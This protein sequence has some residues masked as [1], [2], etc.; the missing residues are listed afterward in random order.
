MKRF[1]KIV[2]CIVAVAAML[3]TLCSCEREPGLYAWYGKVD[4]DNILTMTVNVDGTEKKYDVP[5]MEYRDLFVHY[6]TLVS[7]TVVNSKN[8]EKIATDDQK[9]KAL[10]EYTE[11]EL[12]TYYALVA[13][14]DKFGVPITDDDRAAYENDYNAIVLS[15]ADKLSDEDIKDFDGTKEDYASFVYGKI[16]EKLG[17]TKEYIKYSYFK[18]LLQRKIRTALAPDLAKTVGETYCHFS[19]IYVGFIK[20][21]DVAEQAARAKIDEALAKLESG[22]DFEKVMNEYSTSAEYG[23]EFFIDSNGV[24]VGSEDSDTVGT[25]LLEAVKAL[26]VGEYGGIMTGET[27]DQT[28]YFSIIRRE[29]FDAEDVYGDSIEAIAIYKYPYMSASSYNPCYVAYCDYAEAYEQNM[30]IEPCDPDVYKLVKYGRV[31]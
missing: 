15:Y 11:D 25:T 28:G 17:M 12:R 14:A 21:D 18:K 9:T 4:V 7:D 10:K 16:I 27:D 6:S 29:G 19:Q 30:R 31:Y 1:S 24:I 8:V 13:L 20:G 5:F 3:G 2:C 22:E 26:D 23:R